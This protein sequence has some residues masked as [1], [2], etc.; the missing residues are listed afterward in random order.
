MSMAQRPV[1]YEVP[2]RLFGNRNGRRLPRGTLAENGAGRFADLNDAALEALRSLGVTHLWLVGVLRHATLT[3]WPGLAADPPDI[4]KGVAG[5]YF[6]VRD[7]F[8]VCPEL[9]QTPSK[10]MQEFEALI[11]RIHGHGM[12]A[13][14]DLV[15]NHVGRSYHS[16]VRSELDFGLND[17]RG[18]FFSASNNFFYLVEPEGQGLSIL[19]P[20]GW[21]IDGMSGTFAPEDGSAGHVPRVTGNNQTSPRL[22]P[23][24]WY[25]TVKLNYGYNFVTQEARY[26]PIPNTWWKLDEVIGYWQG[27]GVDGFRCDFAHWIPIEFWRFAIGRARARDAD[28]YFLG[29]VFDNWDAVPGTSK[30]LLIEAGFDAVYDEPAFRTVKRIFQSVGWANDL[31]LLLD[32]TQG[33]GHLLRYLENHDERR[34]ASPVV[35]GVEPRDSGLGSARAGLAAS[36]AMWVSGRGPILLYAGQE[37]GE[38][39]MDAEGYAGVDG[40]TSI[41]DYWSLP[42]LMAWGND[43]EW[44]G[45]KSSWAERECRKAYG[46][47]VGVASRTE[48]AAG[49]CY[50]LN[51]ANREQVSYGERGRW[52]WSHLRY[53]PGGEAASLCVV[54]LSSSESFDVR[55]RIP[56]HAQR[57]AGWPPGAVLTLSP[58]LH[59]Q[60]AFSIRSEE[61]DTAGVPV[62]LPP[63]SAEVF[64]FAL[65][66]GAS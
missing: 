57:L 56:Q 36:A 25:D 11:E 8:D 51:P 23:F 7:Y 2:V 14:I 44:D 20:A 19:G 38:E 1:I 45:G 43:G 48:F 61:A 17:E 33:G 34:V 32:A 50:G 24:D 58:L 62:P 65:R 37:S 63:A 9:A 4:V 6:A 18:V 52:I 49:A 31:G 54:N 55:V 12:R 21:K 26:D 3:A 53:V 42:K 40:R 13:L 59:A 27:K 41:F 46:K 15:P 47:L 35:Q 28:V 16:V 39:G 29:E 64:R 10:R 66:G 60:A 22:G 30:P 5:S